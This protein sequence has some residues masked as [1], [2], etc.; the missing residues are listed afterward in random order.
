MFW[1]LAGVALCVL[2]YGALWR[3]SL[4]VS[5]G[6]LIGLLLAWLLSLFLKPYVTGMETI[7]VW[8]PPIPLAT[9]ALTLFVY[10]AIVWIRGN[11]GLSKK[12]Q[13]ESEED[14]SH[15]AH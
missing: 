4:T 11:E 1:W 3:K 15:D 8:L 9:V 14:H 7:P 13:D 12:K 2:L 10:G 5:F 6:V